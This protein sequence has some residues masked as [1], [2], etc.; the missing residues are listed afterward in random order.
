MINESVSSKF[1]NFKKGLLI[2]LSGPSGVGK[3]TIIEALKLAGTPLTHSISI[4]T[5][6][7]RPGEIDNVSYYFRSREHF[8]ELLETGEILEHD[9]YCGNLYGT[10]RAPIEA[11]LAEGTDVIMD[12]TVPGSLETIVN[13]PDA[14]SI[15]LL[16]PSF[17]EL[18]RRLTNRGTESADVIEQR[19][20]KAIYEVRQAAKFKYIIV[21]EDVNQTAKVIH[22]ILDAERHRSERCIGI[23][24]Y[25]LGR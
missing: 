24:D 5:R 16:P 22:H 3:G 25:I 21:N 9:E 7:P 8:H 20:K 18:R 4:T 15:F 11:L 6:Q 17:S 12:V 2:C 14:I 1:V 19:M 13:F 10:P 23:E